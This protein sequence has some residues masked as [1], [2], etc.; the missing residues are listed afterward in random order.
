MQITSAIKNQIVKEEIKFNKETNVKIV[1]VQSVDVRLSFRQM[2]SI[3]MKI[4]NTNLKFKDLG[5]PP[6]R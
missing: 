1:V 5:Q 6:L 4:V 3:E 2:Y